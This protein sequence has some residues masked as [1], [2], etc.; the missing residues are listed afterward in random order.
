M[1]RRW[2][3]R[4]FA[5]FVI[6]AFAVYAAIPDLFHLELFADPAAASRVAAAA[7]S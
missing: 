7:A 2:V 6:V 3:E 1:R 5:L 4:G